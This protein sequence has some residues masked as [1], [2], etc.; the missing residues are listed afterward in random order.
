MIEAKR[1]HRAFAVALTG[2][3]L[4]IGPAPSWAITVAACRKLCH[5]RFAACARAGGNRAACRTTLI[6]LCQGEGPIAC[7]SASS[8]YGMEIRCAVQAFGANCQ[9][10]IPPDPVAIEATL[11][12]KNV[13]ALPPFGPITV[14]DAAL[15]DQAGSPLATFD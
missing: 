1:P 5:G 13:R 8:P 15:L 14:T 11:T 4:A 3:M 10:F 6:A 12:V 9:P 7:A 2:A